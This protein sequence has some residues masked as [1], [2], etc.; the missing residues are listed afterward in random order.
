MFLSILS[1]SKSEI[2][3]EVKPNKYQATESGLRE[4]YS[5][6]CNRRG[7][8]VVTSDKSEKS[9]EVRNT[10]FSSFFFE[11]NSLSLV[12]IPLY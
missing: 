4:L 11:T 9:T 5:C 6:S 7:G 1:L 12:S 2:A 8:R 10:D 3:D